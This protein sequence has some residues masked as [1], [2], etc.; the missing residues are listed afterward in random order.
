MAVRHQIK[1]T[2]QG[3]QLR[4]FLPRLQRNRVKRAEDIGDVTGDIESFASGCS[5]Q[6]RQT[7]G[8]FHT[9]GTHIPDPV[10]LLAQLDNALPVPLARR[11]MQVR[12]LGY[13]MGTQ[14]ATRRPVAL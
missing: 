14:A 12:Q 11:K 9:E 5:I 13:C 2:A 4:H 6:K 10:R 3:C 8:I 7:K 1:G